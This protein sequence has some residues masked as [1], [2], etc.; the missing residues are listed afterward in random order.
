MGLTTERK[1]FLGLA[2]VAGIALFIDQGLLGP[3][4]ASAIP[5]SPLVEPSPE[6]DTSDARPLTVKPT[7]AILIDRLQSN[8]SDAGV[9]G[10]SNSLG[11][12][13]SLTTISESPTANT[14]NLSDVNI[15]DQDSFPI[16]APAMVDLPTLSAVMPSGNGGAAVLEGTL[17]RIGQVSPSGYQLVLV[18]ARAVIVERDGIEYAI[19]IPKISG[20]D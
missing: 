2:T 11:S 9:P 12:L 14:D 15:E 6:L 5:I 7:A 13:F 19:E 20:Q 17:L 1:I 4:Q 8:V 3:N 10:T 16:I 18:H